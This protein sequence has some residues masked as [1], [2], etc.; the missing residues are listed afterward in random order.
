M[1]S[2]ALPLSLRWA[3]CFGDVNSAGWSGGQCK[4]KGAT[5]W[6]L[7]LPSADPI[8]GE[9]DTFRVFWG[10]GDGNT[11]TGVVR[12]TVPQDKRETVQESTQSSRGP[13][14]EY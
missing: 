3:G 13:P 2:Q 5:P 8:P 14:S 4:W 1:A 11:G 9:K 12:V 6:T 7:F 10:A